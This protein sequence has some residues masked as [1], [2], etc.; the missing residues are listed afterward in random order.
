LSAGRAH[1]AR[2]SKY[3]Q[4]A[5]EPQARMPAFQMEAAERIRGFFFVSMFFAAKSC[6]IIQG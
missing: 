5:G 4:D 2:V 3:R 1:L 6:L